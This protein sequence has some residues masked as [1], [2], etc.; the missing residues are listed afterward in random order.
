MLRETLRLFV[1][2]SIPSLSRLL[3]VRKMCGS[4]LRGALSIAYVGFGSTFCWG[5][6][7]NVSPVHVLRVM[8]RLLDNVRTVNSRHVHHED[9]RSQSRLCRSHLVLEVCE[10]GGCQ[11]FERLVHP[12][13]AA[14]RY[15]KGQIILGA[16]NP[17]TDFSWR[18]VMTNPQHHGL[19]GLPC[20]YHRHD[21]GSL[22]VIL[23]VLNLLVWMPLI[24]CVCCSGAAV[25]YCRCSKLSR[26]V[27][28][29]APHISAVSPR[30]LLLLEPG[31]LQG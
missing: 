14:S 9:S 30:D 16:G 5:I 8:L 7:V 17:L 24:C 29:C 13:L 26:I 31:A 3:A 6:D 4:M 12:L 18:D 21:S 2:A 22:S 28:V 20:P 1:F 23:V 11:E 19:L 27:L 10:S 25:R 15:R